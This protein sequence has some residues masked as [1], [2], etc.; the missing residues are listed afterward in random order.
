LQLPI[1]FAHALSLGVI[2]VTTIFRLK[3]HSLC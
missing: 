2:L 1:V 3:T